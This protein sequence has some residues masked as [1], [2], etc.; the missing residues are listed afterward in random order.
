M[1]H[2]L[3]KKVCFSSNLSKVA[4]LSSHPLFFLAEFLSHNTG[5][6]RVKYCTRGTVHH[7]RATRASLVYFQ[8]RFCRLLWGFKPVMQIQW[9]ER[10][11]SALHGPG[12]RLMKLQ[13]CGLLRQQKEAQSTSGLNTSMMIRLLRLEAMTHRATLGQVWWKLSTQSL[14]F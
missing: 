9:N 2:S 3:T 1:T 12:L 7:C 4:W 14:F 11:G 5:E 6:D 10:D 13:S 8:P